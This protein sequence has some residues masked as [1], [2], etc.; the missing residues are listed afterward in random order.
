MRAIVRMGISRTG[1]VGFIFIGT[2]KYEPQSKWVSKQA[3]IAAAPGLFLSLP[4]APSHATRHDA[5][6]PAACL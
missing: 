1:I 2:E 3:F 6:S 4:H 5:S